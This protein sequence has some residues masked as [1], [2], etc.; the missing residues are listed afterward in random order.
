MRKVILSLAFLG[1]SWSGFAQSTSN[2]S[3]SLQACQGDTI[4]FG[5]NI[6]SPFN[7]GNTFSVEMSDASGNFAGNFVSINALLAYGVSTGNEIDVLVPDNTTQGVYKFRMISS[8]PVVISDTIS[9]VII[10]ANPETAIT[11]FNWFDKAGEITFCEG[12]T[13]LLVANQPPAGQSYTYQWL[14]GG[15]PMAGEINDTLFVIASGTYALEVSSNLCDA[16]SNDTIVNSY[17]P[18]TD[19]YAQ[20]GSG[21]NY[22][23]MDSIRMCYG[24]VATLEY[25]AFPSPGI[26]DYK[27]RW[28]KDDSTNIFGQPVMYALPNDTLYTIDVDTTGTWY[29][30][31]TSIPGGCVDTSEVFTVIV[32]TVPATVVDVAM[33]SY[34]SLP[35]TT[36]CLTDSVM[37]VAQDTVLNSSWEYQW[38]VA[39]PSGSGNWLN[40]ANDTLPWLKVD[41]SIVADTADYRLLVTNEACSF[42]TNEQTINFVNFPSIL[43]QPGDSLGICVYDSVLVSLQSNALNFAWNGGL[44]TGKQNF[45]SVP[46]QYVIEAFGVNQCKTIDTLDIYNYTLVAAASANPPVISPGESTV[47]SATG[48]VSYYWFADAPSYYSNQQ[49]STTQALPSVDTITYFIQVEDLNGCEDTASVQV[50]VVEQDSAVIYAG[51]Y[52]NIQNVITPNG[53]GRNDVL[54][55]SGI[56]AGDDCELTVFTR[57]GTPV[58]NQEVYNNAWGG[59]TDGGSALEDGTY[60]FVLTHNNEIRVKSAVTILNNF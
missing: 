4:V 14:I 34:Q 41:T 40:L 6:T 30:E 8:N 33:W 46:G 44:Y 12:D 24:T 29:L 2:E 60:Y 35:T 43:I 45:L 17:I 49:S 5:F 11:A 59:T 52:G 53:D 9:N 31:V 1:F 28:L 58:Y 36:L 25:F 32:D 55:L 19:V 48:G 15:G 39:Y 7:I 50:F 47:L 13:A 37:L 20:S 10:G 23:G 54:D 38:Q 26:T 51:T 3:L 16:T 18:P 57:W 27:Y 22:V 42:I 56:T 21:V